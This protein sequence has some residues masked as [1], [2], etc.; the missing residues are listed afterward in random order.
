VL[1]AVLAVTPGLIT[2]RFATANQSGGDLA[3]REDFWNAAEH[4]WEGHPVLGVG[5]GGFPGAYASARLPAKQFLPD[6]VLEPPPHAHNLFLQMLAE[7]GI[8][9]LLSLLAIIGV[10]VRMALELRRHAERWLRVLGSAMLAA[11]VAFLIHN[12][13]DVTLIEETGIDFWAMLGLLSAL[14]AIGREAPVE[15]AA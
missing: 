1:V 15:H 12:M 14:S 4:I 5:L 9:G 2:E 6:S 10:A 8:L 11:L 3:T 13:F 7:Q